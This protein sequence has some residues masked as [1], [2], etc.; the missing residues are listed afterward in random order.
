MRITLL[1][2][3]MLAC[4]VFQDPVASADKPDYKVDTTDIS[5]VTPH[6]LHA[7]ELDGD[8][9]GCG[10]E[11][12]IFGVDETGGEDQKVML[13]GA[14]SALLVEDAFGMILQTT[15]FD[16]QLTDEP[17][18]HAGES[19]EVPY[20]YLIGPEGPAVPDMERSRDCEIIDLKMEGFCGV[21]QEDQPNTNTVIGAMMTGRFSVVFKR[22]VDGPEVT[23]PLVPELL[24]GGE[25]Y[26]PKMRGCMLRQMEW[27]RSQGYGN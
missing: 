19:F 3:V 10:M 6:W 20:A 27:L 23:V 5:D 22:T 21:L 17:G 12:L 24:V 9:H 15:A 7:I 4:V 11:F 2:V 13:R 26:F 1:I 25:D 16:L 8:I 14:V 18:K